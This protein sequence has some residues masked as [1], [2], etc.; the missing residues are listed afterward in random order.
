MSISSSHQDS[1]STIVYAS[2]AASVHSLQNGV[3]DTRLPGRDSLRELAQKR[4]VTFEHL[5]K[6][7]QGQGLYFGTLKLTKEDLVLNYDNFKMRKRS[8][9]YFTLGYSLASLLE[10]NNIQDFLK[11]VYALLLEYETW[12]NDTGKMTMKKIFRIN[13]TEE[14]AM[15]VNTSSS[16]HLH[17]VFLDVRN[18]PFDVDYLQVFSALCDIISRFY[19]KLDTWHGEMETVLDMIT[20]IDARFKKIIVQS[21]KELDALLRQLVRQEITLLDLSLSRGNGLEEWDVGSP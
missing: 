12:N 16:D 4:M 8:L 5:R 20:K 18:I 14:V 17:L 19:G 2:S 1:T 11:S 13:R 21:Q 3:S 10:I 6:T 15:D 7:Y 9:H